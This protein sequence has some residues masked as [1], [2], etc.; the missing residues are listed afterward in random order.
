MGAVKNWLQSY[1]SPV[2]LELGLSL[3]K[4]S[5]ASLNFSRRAFPRVMQCVH[6]Y[7]TRLSVYTIYLDIL[8]KSEV[9]FRNIL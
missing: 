3:A 2:E 7:V 5:V 8:Q 6:E 9:R 4:T 1:L